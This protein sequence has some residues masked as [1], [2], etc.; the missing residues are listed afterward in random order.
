MITRLFAIAVVGMGCRK[1]PVMPPP[2]DA[3][4][5]VRDA[6][7]LVCDAPARAEP[8]IAKGGSRSDAISLHLT[9]GVGNDRVLTMVE[10]WKTNGIDARALDALTTEAKVKTCAL[11]STVG[12]Q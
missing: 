1:G 11:R 9:D 7:V 10:G 3:D 2:G 8:E 5:S 12:G 4:Q 6:V